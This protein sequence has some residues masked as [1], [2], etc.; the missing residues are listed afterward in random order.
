MGLLVSSR[1]PAADR[2]EVLWLL[3]DSDG[4]PLRGCVLCGRIFGTAVDDKIL[5]G[6]RTGGRRH[7]PF[8]SCFDD[9]L[10]DGGRCGK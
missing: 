10:V 1:G 6:A 7:G 5:S 4:R 8:C 3:T 2:N 9:V